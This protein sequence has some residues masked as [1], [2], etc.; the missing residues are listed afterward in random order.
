MSETG[1]RDGLTG[2]FPTTGTDPIPAEPPFESRYWGRPGRRPATLIG[3]AALLIVVMLA[4]V[5]LGSVRVPL[6]DVLA[7][8][9]GGERTGALRFII[10]NLRLPRVLLA[11]LVGMNLAVAGALLQS[12]TRNPLA[13]P[14]LLG[15]SAGGALLA[16]LAVHIW[17]AT[18][19]GNLPMLAFVGALIGAL[20]LYLIAW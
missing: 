15:L 10:W 5:A 1:Q 7:V 4:G 2:T 14:Q 9:F 18:A 19:L 8:V 16:V 17:P 3:A 6:S 12:V 13:D 20:L 11:V